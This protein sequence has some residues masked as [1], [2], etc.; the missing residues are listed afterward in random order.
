MIEVS[1][2]QFNACPVARLVQALVERNAGRSPES[3]LSTGAG[4]S[5]IAR[6]AA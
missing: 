4:N 3:W 2:P 5:V 6:Y 1:A